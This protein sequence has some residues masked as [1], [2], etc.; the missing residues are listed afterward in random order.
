LETLFLGLGFFVGPLIWVTA[1]KDLHVVSMI[2][3]LAIRLLQVVDAHSGYD[4]PISLHHFLPFWA[5]A[6]FH[7]Y[8]HQVFFLKSDLIGVCWKL[9]VFV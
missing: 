4:F 8:H 1:T 3:W 5:G 7:D 6:D 2:S 9:F